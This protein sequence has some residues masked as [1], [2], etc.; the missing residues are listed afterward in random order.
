MHFFNNQVYFFLEKPPVKPILYHLHNTFAMVSTAK[1][2]VTWFVYILQ[3]CDNTL[4]TGIT[5]DIDRR[6]R[7]HNSSATG[8]KYTKSR[9]PVKLVYRENA[10]SRSAAAAREFQIKRLDRAGKKRLIAKNPA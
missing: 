9:Q 6:V 4:Y 5:T 2:E 1:S 7:E 8:S 3:C 10:P